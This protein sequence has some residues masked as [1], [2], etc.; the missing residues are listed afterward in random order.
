MFGQL[1]F[2]STSVLLENENLKRFRFV[3][4]KVF[5]KALFVL[6]KKVLKAK[7]N[8]NNNLFVFMLSIINI[9]INQA[10]AFHFS[11]K[12]VTWS[13]SGFK[14]NALNFEYTKGLQS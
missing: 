9:Q 6:L 7:T 10:H 14:P 13:R 5:D 4:G 12:T 8:K 2:E 3:V 11:C 1:L